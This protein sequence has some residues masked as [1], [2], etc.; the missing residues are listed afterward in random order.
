MKNAPF[1]YTR[2]CTKRN[3]ELWQGY[4]VAGEMS[5][6]SVNGLRI[7]NRG[8]MSSQSQSAEV[9]DEAHNEG[10]HVYKGA[11]YTHARIP[12]RTH[13]VPSAPRLIGEDPCDASFRDQLCK[14]QAAYSLVSG[15]P[16]DRA[17]CCVYSSLSVVPIRKRCYDASTNQHGFGYLSSNHG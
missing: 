1:L 14:N 10:Y 15:T 11:G 13:A 12:G 3:T 7:Q 2:I 8:R 4:P 16:D 17:V 5:V 9:Y 6:G